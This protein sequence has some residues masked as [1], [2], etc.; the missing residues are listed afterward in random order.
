MKK[1]TAIFLTVIILATFVSCQAQMPNVGESGLEIQGTQ[2]GSEVKKEFVVGDELI[3]TSPTPLNLEIWPEYW[4]RILEVKV[5]KTEILDINDPEDYIWVGFEKNFYKYKYTIKIQG[6]Y[7][8]REAGRYIKIRLDF[9][10]TMDLVQTYFDY[11]IFEDHVT[12]SYNH[13][14]GLYEM[15]GCVFKIKGDGT[16]SGEAVAYSNE[17]VETFSILSVTYQA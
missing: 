9:D 2:G 14:T 17:D 10:G 1:M 6:D 16:F 3:N 15:N 8:A 13:F 4:V 12:G 7:D 5:I 11:D